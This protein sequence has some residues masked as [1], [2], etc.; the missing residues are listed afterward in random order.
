[1]ACHIASTSPDEMYAICVRVCVCV[2]DAPR[3]SALREPRTFRKHGGYT[4]I[5]FQAEGGKTNFE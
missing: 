4:A 2:C 3:L 5:H 1:M